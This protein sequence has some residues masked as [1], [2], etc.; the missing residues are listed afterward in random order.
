MISRNEVGKIWMDCDKQFNGITKSY[1]GQHGRS[2]EDREENRPGE[3]GHP[4]LHG[5]QIWVEPQT[6]P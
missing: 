4:C 5:E 6:Q 1:V 2:R 3:E